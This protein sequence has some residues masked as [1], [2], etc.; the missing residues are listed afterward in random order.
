MSES[1]A[2]RI[3][4]VEHRKSFPHAVP[5]SICGVEKSA[6]SIERLTD[7]PERPVVGSTS[8]AELEEPQATMDPSNRSRKV[9]HYCQRNGERSFWTAWNSLG[10]G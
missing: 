7:G 2:S 8:L 3:A 4:I 10:Q 6:V 9:L 1:P 5:N